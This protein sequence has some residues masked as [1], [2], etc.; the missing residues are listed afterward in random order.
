VAEARYC[1]WMERDNR[2]EHVRHL[3]EAFARG[4][5]D[6]VVD[7]VDDDVEWRLHGA[8]GRTLR[9]REDLRRYMEQ[10]AAQGDRIEAEPYS[11]EEYGDCVLVSGH[12]RIRTDEGMTDTQLYGLYS[13]AN[14]RLVRFDA[15]PS[16]DQALAAV[17]A[18]C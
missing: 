12:L 4:G 15:F 7:I 18:H 17:Q 14:G 1:T 6:E 9:G 10:R 13:F 16:R 11:Y 2:V 8:P 5:I 3:W